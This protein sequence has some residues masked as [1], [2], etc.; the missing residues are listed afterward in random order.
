MR[1]AGSSSRGRMVALLR[2]ERLTVEQLGSSLRLTGNAVRA[3]LS[4][5]GRDGVVEA[6]GEVR[7]GT[8]G[9]PSTLYGLTKGTDTLFSTAYAPALAA[10]VAELGSTHPE[11]FESLLRG[12]GRRLA[13]PAAGAFADRVAAAAQVLDGLGTDVEVTKEDDG[14]R[15]TG[16]G[17]VL[18]Q[19]V[20][21]N[22]AT[23]CVLEQL[24][25]D[26]TGADV[27]EQCDRSEYPPKCGFVIRK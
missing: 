20:L 25:A 7:D 14:Y 27:R 26:V 18:A 12:A 9:K 19:A 8:V 16:H 5:L 23:C 24:L 10:L 17:C 6:A 2:R 1:N 4:T 3:Q 22:P 15:L 11:E 21:A 13:R